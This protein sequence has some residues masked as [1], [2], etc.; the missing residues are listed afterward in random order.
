[1]YARN[2]TVGS[3]AP[4]STATR[5]LFGTVAGPVASLVAG[6]IASTL[7]AD[8]VTTRYISGSSYHL[9]INDMPDL[10][11]QRDGL[12]AWGACQ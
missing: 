11:Q 9:Q 3:A 10:D 7:S 8:F 5:R 6:T 2:Q 4:V 1:M 12:G